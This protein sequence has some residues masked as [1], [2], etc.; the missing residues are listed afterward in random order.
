MLPPSYAPSVLSWN[1][2]KR[3]NLRCA[4][5]YLDAGEAGR[6]ELSTEEA[7][8]V[9]EQ[10]ARAGTELLI[11]SGGE[12]LMRK[13]LFQIAG[14]ASS[15]GVAV[16]LGT[17]GTL[18]TEETIRRIQEAG[19]QGLGVSL[20]STDANKHDTFRGVTGAW[21]RAVV[22]IHRS[23]KAGIPVLVQSTATP[24]NYHEIPD[25]IS[26][27]AGLGAT[28]FTLYFLVCTGRG[29]KLTDI[30][31]AQYERA[32][33]SLVDA[34]GKYPGMLLR[35]KCAP[36]LQRIARLAGSGLAASA[37]CLAGTH[38][39]RIT[40]EGDVTPCPYLPLTV[41]NVKHTELA[42]IWATSPLLRQFRSPPLGGRCGVCD[43]RKECGGC[44]ARAYA[45]T[46]DLWADDTFCGYQPTPEIP[47]QPV[48]S[49]VA[50]LTWHDEAIARLERV[51][52]FIRGRV[53]AG[54][55]SFALA[56]GYRAV[57]LSVL[58]EV[59]HSVGHPR[60][61]RPGSRGATAAR[62]EDRSMAK[63]EAP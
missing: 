48:S 63:P 44:R 45:T 4:H 13:D 16:V 2:T 62:L 14:H 40:P 7:L 25:L 18:I 51:P 60:N 38:Y 59:L 24:W 3:C 23:I 57:D 6:G 56:K 22:G 28:G 11:I 15:L 53:K 31:P 33:A 27:A 32:L 8:R 39:G 10:C 17:N 54:V 52:G 37:G 42:Q 30:T 46:G 35:A 58:E 5:C 61:F 19:V 29:E 26:F 47:A 50:S 43:Y 12:P 49:E 55:E 41:G 9:V 20:D 21:A 1:L 34:Q 36:Q